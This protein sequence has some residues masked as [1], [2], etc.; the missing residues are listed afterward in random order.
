MNKEE[1]LKLV[2]AGF[3]KDE[4]LKLFSD[5]SVEPNVSKTEEN[6]EEQKVAEEPSNLDTFTNMFD[7]MNKRLES[8]TKAIQSNNVMNASVDTE[9]KKKTNEDII[10]SIILPNREGE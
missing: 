3:T 4:I 2:N 1:L 7:E 9:E 5:E 6:S 10:A 8:M